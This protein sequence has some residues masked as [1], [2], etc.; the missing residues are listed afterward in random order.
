MIELVNAVATEEE[1]HD[2]GEV[3]GEFI[4]CGGLDVKTMT[5]ETGEEDGKDDDLVDVAIEKS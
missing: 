5:K 4:E 1:A 3:F 2:V